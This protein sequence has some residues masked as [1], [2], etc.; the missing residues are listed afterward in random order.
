[1]ESEAFVVLSWKVDDRFI[2]SDDDARLPRLG[3]TAPAYHTGRS[4]ILVWVDTLE[5][6]PVC[7]YDCATHPH[8]FAPNFRISSLLPSLSSH[9][10]NFP[11]RGRDVIHREVGAHV[12]YWMKTW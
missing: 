4:L 10:Y 2:T 9:L 7:W 3:R 5:T 8:A 12:L 1:M 11:K 6:L